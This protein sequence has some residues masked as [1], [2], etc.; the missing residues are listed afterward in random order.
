MSLE[1]RVVNRG[2]WTIVLSELVLDKS[3]SRK[4]CSGPLPGGA[5]I[6]MQRAQSIIPENKLEALVTFHNCSDGADVFFAVAGDAF[7]ILFFPVYFPNLTAIDIVFGSRN[8]QC[9]GK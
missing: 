6:K 3:F 9:C 8:A 2:A 5:K 1:K 4:T 7:E